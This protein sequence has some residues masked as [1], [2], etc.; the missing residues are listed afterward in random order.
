MIVMGI[1]NV[2]WTTVVNCKESVG[3]ISVFQT[4]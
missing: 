2:E 3:N 1:G 4:Q